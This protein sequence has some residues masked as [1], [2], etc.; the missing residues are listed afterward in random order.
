MFYNKP[1]S[2]IE[3]NGECTVIIKI[4]NGVRQGCPLSMLLFG[5]IVERLIQK[6]TNNQNIKGLKFGK[7]ILKMLV[8]ADDMVMFLTT[9][10]GIIT[11]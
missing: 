4:L 5:V 9:E 3:I 6:I 7:S 2:K 1:I 8:C 11:M 10:R